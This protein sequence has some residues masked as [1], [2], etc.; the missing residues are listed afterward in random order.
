MMQKY[1][2]LKNKVT[3]IRAVRVNPAGAM[4]A[5]SDNPAEYARL[6]KMAIANLRR[7]ERDDAMRSIGL[8]KVRGAVSGK[9]YWE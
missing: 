9:T 2:L 1:T 6:R 8:K 3:G 7:T 4:I 5:E